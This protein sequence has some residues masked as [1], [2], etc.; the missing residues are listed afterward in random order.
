[1][2]GFG[3]AQAQNERLKLSLELRAVNN[4]YFKLSLRTQD[5]LV[6]LENQIEAHLRR[7]IRRGTVTVYIQVQR[8]ARP[9]Q[10]RLNLTALNAYREQLLQ[11]R[12]NWGLEPQVEPEA[13]LHLPGVV[14]EALLEHDVQQDWPLVQQAL[15]QAFQQLQ[16]MRRREGEAMAAQLR[17]HCQRIGQLADQIAQRA[18]QV[19][20]EYQQRLLQRLQQTL[21]ELDLELDK[22]DVLREVSLFA[23]RVDISEEVVRLKSHLEQFLRLLESSESVGRRL[24]FVSQEMLREINTIGAKANDSQIAHLMVE[25]KAEVERIR[26]LVQNIE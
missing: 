20:P 12:Q 3:Q 24:D 5:P 8:L 25:A 26:E 21:G 9:D 14:D 19:A 7:V 11:L 18:T 15:D 4:R 23:E 16:Q 17:Q 6:L 13:L 1:M 2:T 10:F 22:A